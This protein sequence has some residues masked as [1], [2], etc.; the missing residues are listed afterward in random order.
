M[1]TEEKVAR[2]Y[3]VMIDCHNAI[4]FAETSSVN[5]IKLVKD[6]DFRKAMNCKLQL[7]T[8]KHNKRFN[9]YI[10]A[11]NMGQK[12]HD[13]R[14]GSG[15]PFAKQVFQT[16]GFGH[17]DIDGK[18]MVVNIKDEEELPESE[19]TKICNL[20]KEIGLLLKYPGKQEELF[21]E[22]RKNYHHLVYS[23]A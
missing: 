12:Y 14:F 6:V 2:V 8:S 5:P 16:L 1:S 9:I 13:P 4:G 11:D 18:I 10:D 20:F 15:I 22:I 21:L 7:L 19:V 23:R 3:G 17:L